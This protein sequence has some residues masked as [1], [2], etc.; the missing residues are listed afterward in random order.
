[1]NRIINTVLVIVILSLVTVFFGFNGINLTID[2]VNYNSMEKVSLDDIEKGN[3]K[4]GY[5]RL[6]GVIAYYPYSIKGYNILSSPEKPSALYFPII[7]KEELNKNTLPIPEKKFKILVRDENYNKNIVKQKEEL[8]LGELSFNAKIVS[9]DSIS[10]SVIK[11]IKN[12]QIFSKYFEPKLLY[13]DKVDQPVSLILIILM[14]SL[15]I[16]AIVLIVIVI[17]NRGVEIVRISK[18]N[19]KLRNVKDN[20]GEL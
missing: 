10:E 14:Y 20:I 2:R 5:V 18:D 9:E 6:E 16:F 11:E 7:K 15:A 13:I 19:A 8:P 3:I 1:M 4:D 17:R 12:S